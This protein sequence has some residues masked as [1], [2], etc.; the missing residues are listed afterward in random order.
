MYSKHVVIGCEYQS[1]NAKNPE[2]RPV[3]SGFCMT[4]T[5]DA[6]EEHLGRAI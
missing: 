6:F 5:S 3:L 2:R 4:H 1:K